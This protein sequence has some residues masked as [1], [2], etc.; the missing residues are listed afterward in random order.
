MSKKWK[1]SLPDVSEWRDGELALATMQI[2]DALTGLS[3]RAMLERVAYAGAYVR[4]YRKRLDVGS[5]WAADW[6]EHW[7]G[8]YTDTELLWGALRY[9]ASA[10]CEEVE[11]QARE[12]R[13]AEAALRTIWRRRQQERAT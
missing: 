13:E 3:V 10:A 5:E 2:A 12:L 9:V 8:P 11:W 1:N 6:T 7:G 4:Q